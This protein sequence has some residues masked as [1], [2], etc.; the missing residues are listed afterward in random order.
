[1]LKH[2]IDSLAK[3]KTN[4]VRV[5]R[6]GDYPQTEKATAQLVFFAGTRLRVEYWRLVCNGE[7][8]LSRFDHEQ[9]YGLPEPI[10]AFEG[11]QKGLN[12]KIVTDAILEGETGDLRSQF[13]ENYKLQAFAFSGY[14]V[15]EISFPGGTGEYSNYAK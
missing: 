15:R 11:L 4:S 3:L 14:E 8:P 1:M 5:L 9:Q 10:D 2:L 7:E 6:A 13:T 12:E